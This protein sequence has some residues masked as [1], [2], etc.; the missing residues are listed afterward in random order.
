MRSLAVTAVVLLG[1]GRIGFVGFDATSNAPVDTSTEMPLCTGAFGPPLPIP[2]INTAENDSGP[3]LT[4]DGLEL[5]FFSSRQTGLGGSD[6]WHATRTDP[7]LPFGAPTLL[8]NVNSVD[9]DGG[10]ALTADGLT[11]YFSSRRPGG[12]GLDDIWVSKRPD[13]ASPF[14]AA[15][16][17]DTASSPASEYDPTPSPDGRTLYVTSERGGGAGADIWMAS[18]VGGVADFSSAT[19]VTEL[20]SGSFDGGAS[21][22]GDGKTVVFYSNRQD[23]NLEIFIATRATTTDAF[24]QVARIPSVSSGAAEAATWLS[25]DGQTVLFS[26]N[27]AGGAGGAD[28]YFATR[29]C[30]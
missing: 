3:R 9:D 21:V 6:L 5:V 13:L 16:N 24:S 26:S 28:L 29:T 14:S 10:A 2:G 4:P 11:L 12:R 23:T 19:N 1:C 15:V 27:R 7:T 18:R 8:P 20:N 25:S 30:P 17:V 22:S